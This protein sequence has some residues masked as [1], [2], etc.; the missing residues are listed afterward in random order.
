MSLPSRERELK[1]VWLMEIL[2]HVESLPSRE[3]ELKHVV[4]ELRL[5]VEVAPLAGA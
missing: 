4:G 5:I 3:R 1:H 2:F